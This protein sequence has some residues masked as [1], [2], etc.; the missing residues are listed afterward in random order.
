MSVINYTFAFFVV[1][2]VYYMLNSLMIFYYSVKLRAF[3]FCTHIL[4]A[5]LQDKL[6]V[7]GDA[8]LPDTAANVS[9]SWTFLEDLDFMLV[10]CP[11]LFSHSY[12]G[13]RNW[14][15]FI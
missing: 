9:C 10:I 8:E 14:D 7:F 15:R 11:E 12:F 4:S 2:V 5:S 1:F 13:S 6:R 3:V